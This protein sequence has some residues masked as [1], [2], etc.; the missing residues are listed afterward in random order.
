MRNQPYHLN[1]S[2]KRA[3][4][5]VV[6]PLIP[7]DFW[8]TKVNKIELDYELFLPNKL[9]RDISNVLSVVDKYACDALTEAGVIPDDNYEHLQKVVYRYGGMDDNGKG[10]VLMTIKE[11]E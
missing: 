2:L 9:K 7:E 11:V 1:N 4:K 10:Y 3:M 5:E 8:G 6:L